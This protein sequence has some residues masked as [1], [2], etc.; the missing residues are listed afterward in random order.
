MQPIDEPTESR[1]G[2]GG[3]SRAAPAHRL[4]RSV[5]GPAARVVL[6][7]EIDCD[8]AGVVEETLMAAVEER[9]VRSVVVDLSDLRFMDVRCAGVL[10]GARR[11]ADQRGVAMNVAYVSGIPRRVLE[12]LGLYD[13]LLSS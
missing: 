6:S 3:E 11:R 13:E 12:I 1:D 7:G 9:G 4:D 2:Y 5:R 10:L 8:C